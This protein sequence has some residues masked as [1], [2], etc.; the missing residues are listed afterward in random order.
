[1]TTAMQRPSRD[2]PTI[3]FSL[4]MAHRRTARV[5]IETDSVTILLDCGWTKPDTGT[6]EPLRRVAP[7]VDL[8]S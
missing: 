7:A 3:F 8:Y 5:R 2:L 6:I 1:M 4:S